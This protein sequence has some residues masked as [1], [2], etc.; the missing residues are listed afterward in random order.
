MHIERD[1]GRFDRF[2]DHRFDQW[3]PH[4]DRSLLQSVLFLPTHAATLN[5]AADAGVHPR[6]VLDLGCGTG[7]LLERAAERWPDA[8]F[9][10]VDVAPGMITEAKRK[11]ANDAR[12]RF[13]VGDAAALPLEPASIDVALSTISFHHWADQTGGVRQVARVL[14]PAGHFVLADIRP[15]FLL[16]PIMRRFHASRS[17]ERLFKDAGL[18]VVKQ[19]RLPRFGGYVLITVGRKAS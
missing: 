19:R 13:E 6:D 4:Y 7:L 15:P 17:R 12:F 10:G 3:A 8:R 16:G 9:V 1:H 11:H 2:F 5:A 18:T 14:R